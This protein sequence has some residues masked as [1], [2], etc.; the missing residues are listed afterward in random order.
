MIEIIL[1]GTEPLRGKEWYTSHKD[2]YTHEFIES[3]GITIIT[4]RRTTTINSKG[5]KGI[6]KSIIKGG[7]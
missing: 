5:K 7:K 2:D 4:E 1:I 6:I 3:L